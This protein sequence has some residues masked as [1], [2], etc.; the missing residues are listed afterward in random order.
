MSI[1]LVREQRFYLPFVSTVLGPIKLKI[2]GSRTNP[3]Y[4]PN[5]TIR[6]NTRKNTLNT[7]ILDVHNNI[8]AN[9]VENPPWKTAGPISMSV[10]LTLSFLDDT[11]CIFVK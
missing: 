9:K 4:S 7:K 2:T 11:S 5:T 1:I 6:K 8:K 10:C 3:L